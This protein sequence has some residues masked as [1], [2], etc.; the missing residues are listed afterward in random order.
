MRRFLL[1]TFCCSVLLGIGLS[2]WG[3]MR[4]TRAGQPNG[5]AITGAYNEPAATM[6]GVLKRIT[7]KSVIIAADGDQIVTMD[8]T[9]KTKFFK[10]GKEVKPEEI[11]EG[12]VVSV[13]VGKDPQLA[14][15]AVNVR[16]DA[17][18]VDGA[19]KVDQAAAKKH[20]DDAPDIPEED[21]AGT[22]K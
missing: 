7:K 22:S 10:Q 5:T 3:Q 9:R 8:R 18:A 16:V 19:S 4:R 1:K 20:R 2:A 12:S 21:P 13:D 6:H 14:P 11:A 15:L 17:P